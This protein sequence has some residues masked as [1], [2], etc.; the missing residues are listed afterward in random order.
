[1]E[2]LWDTCPAKVKIKVLNS[3]GA[4]PG[5]PTTLSTSLSRRK[6]SKTL[7]VAATSGSAHSSRSG[8][9]CLVELTE[10]PA[11]R[12]VEAKNPRG[13]LNVHCAVARPEKGPTSV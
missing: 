6:H 7:Q 4:C 5:L 9:V 2:P 3:V 8:M 10:Q 13:A 1:M 12:T 11:V